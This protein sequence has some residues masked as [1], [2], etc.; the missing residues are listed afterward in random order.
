MDVPLP[1]GFALVRRIGPFD[2]DTM[3]RGLLAEHRLKPDRWGHLV[4]QSGR[5]RL[6]WEDASRPSQDLVAPAEALIPPQA[7]HHLELLG[8]V[9][10]AIAFLERAV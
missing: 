2:A 1:A 3:P 7:P 10:L 8:D 6:V 4:V 5:V 9:E